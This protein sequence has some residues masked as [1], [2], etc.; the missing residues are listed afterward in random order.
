YEL[1]GVEAG[2]ALVVR[3]YSEVSLPGAAAPIEVRAGSTLEGVDLTLEDAGRIAVRS[4]LEAANSV[5]ATFL[6]VGDEKVEPVGRRLRDGAAVLDGLRPGRW[7][8]ALQGRDLGGVA[9]RE[10]VVEARVTAQLQF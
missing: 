10:V 3:A 1:R 6:D 7:R 2:V 4:T 5:S 8:V 9:P